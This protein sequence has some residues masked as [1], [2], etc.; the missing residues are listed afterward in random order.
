M[1]YSD[2]INFKGKYRKYDPYGKEI[3][4]FTGDTVFFDTSYFTATRTITGVHPLTKNSGWEKLASRTN[5]YIQET[6]PDVI[7]TSG[8]RW[9]RPS[10][11][12][13]YTRIEDSNGMHWVEL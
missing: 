6:T 5:F 9:Y 3:T 7:S 8:D 12:V 10:V 1:S 11:G 4:Y 13:V 2:N